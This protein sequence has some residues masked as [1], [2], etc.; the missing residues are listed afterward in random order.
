MKHF[1]S[2]KEVADLTGL[3]KTS[4]EIKQNPHADSELGRNKTLG[5]VF[6]NS[7]LRTRMST[8]R[9][10][11]NLGMNVIALNVSS[12]SWQ[13]EFSD[14]IRMDGGTAEHIREAV[15][16]L[17]SYCDIIGVRSFPALV[18]REEDYS[19]KVI[20]SFI[21]FGTCPVVNLESATLH[22]LQ[23]FTDMMTIEEFKSVDR[24]KVVMTWAPHIK[25]LPQAVSNSFLQ[26]AKQMDFELTITHPEGLELASEF[27]EGIQVEYNQEKAF[28][29]ADFVYVKNW[30]SY[31]DYGK[32]VDQPDWEITLEKLRNTNEAKVMHCLPVR[33][34]VVIADNVLD[35]DHSIVIPQAQNR[36]FTAQTI[37]KEI[38]TCL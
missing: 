11:Y 28:E 12:D 18:N 1:I 17:C 35:S 30:S 32:V 20:N 23:S 19:E 22:P 6:F 8:T 9:A 26:W 33:R 27:T 5:L 36:L 4:K 3:I 24:P 38:L 10:A 21:E 31:Q 14:G 7:S 16:V 34:N 37:L 15:P 13:L 2:T 25:A 29:K